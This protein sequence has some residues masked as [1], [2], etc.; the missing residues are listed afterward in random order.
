MRTTKQKIP[1]F[2]L[3]EMIVDGII[4]RQQARQM[5]A[6]GKAAGKRKKE[7]SIQFEG[8]TMTTYYPPIAFRP[9]KAVGNEETNIVTDGMRE[10][11][12]EYAA[13]TKPIFNRL[14]NKYTVS[15]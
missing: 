13:E 10:L 14:V 3:E 4:T 9:S 2:R 5:I 7:S 8:S 1:F 6:D 11:Q 12:R 15:G